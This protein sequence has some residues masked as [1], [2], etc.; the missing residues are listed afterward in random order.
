MRSPC[1]A[2][3]GPALNSCQHGSCGVRCVTQLQ[4][5]ELSCAMT[6]DEPL[7]SGCNVMSC[8]ATEEAT[9]TCE[10]LR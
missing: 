4:M 1:V 7:T 8:I 9:R 6:V 3:R 10:G 5:D 2:L